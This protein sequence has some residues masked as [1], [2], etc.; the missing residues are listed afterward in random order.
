M[1]VAIAEKA[2]YKLPVPSMV[3]GFAI[4]FWVACVYHASA[5]EHSE[6]QNLQASS[7][8]LAPAVARLVSAT[9]IKLNPTIPSGSRSTPWPQTQSEIR[10]VLELPGLAFSAARQSAHE[11]NSVPQALLTVH[12]T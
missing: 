5:D 6:V 11:W 4:L 2:A 8:T 1:L 7:W 9:E 10:E 12:R 3:L